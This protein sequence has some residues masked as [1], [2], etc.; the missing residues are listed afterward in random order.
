MTISRWLWAY[1]THH[2]KVSWRTFYCMLDFMD[3]WQLEGF[4]FGG[5][6]FHND[7]I[8]HHTK[9]KPMFREKG[10]FKRN[11][12]SFE[13]AILKPIE[14]RLSKTTQRV[15][16]V[17]NHDRW[18][19]DLIEEQPE[20]DGIIERTESLRLVERG[21]KIVKNGRSFTNGKLIC[22][23][24]DELSGFGNQTP[25]NHSKKAVDIYGK[26]V[27]YGH[28]HAPQSATKVSPVDMTQKRMAWC[29]P[30]LG[31]VNPHY[32]RNRPTAWLNGFVVVE[33]WGQSGSFNLYPIV[34]VEGKFSY[35]GKFYDVSKG[36]K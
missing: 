10:A 12:I 23:H 6:Q 16:L 3:D 8:S 29:A 18:E 17:G 27:L 19:S 4:G 33:F 32:L 5:D 35:G 15:W 2:P 31:N 20:L 9:N 13:R 28:M 36:S 22:S 25:Q 26:N 14:E 7:E 30:I 24:G 1:D 34:V 11:T 21:W